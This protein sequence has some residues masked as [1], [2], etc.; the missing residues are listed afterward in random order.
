MPYEQYAYDL[1]I[2]Y[3]KLADPCQYKQNSNSFLAQVSNI[4]TEM[5]I[6]FEK[7]DIGISFTS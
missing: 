1:N 4:C 7:L 2:K 6:F 3:F 5:S